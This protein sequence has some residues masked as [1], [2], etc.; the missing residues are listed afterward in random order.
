LLEKLCKAWALEFQ[1][2][3]L[4]GS[5]DSLRSTTYLQHPIF[6]SYHS[7]TAMLRYIRSLSDRD[8]ALDRTMI[9]LGSCTMKLNATTEMEAITW[10]EFAFLHPFAPAQQSQGTRKLIS[11][12]SKW[13]IDITGYD[14]VSLQPNAGSQG[15]FAGLLAIKNYLASNGE[16][17][18]DICLIPSSAHGTNAASAVMAGMR[19]VVVSCDEEGNVSLADLKEKIEQYR[20]ELAALMV[21]Y[22]STHGVFESEITTIC[23][24]IHDAGGQVYVD[25]ANLNAL[26]GL[27]QPGKFGADVSHLNLH[28]TFCIPHGG[29]GPGVGPVIARKH[30]APHLPNHPLDPTAGP[31]TGAGPISSAPFGS[32]LILPISWAYIRMMGAQGLTHATEVAI[33]SAN[34]I[35][36]KLS[37]HYPILYTGKNGLIAHECI[38]DLRDITKRTGV[39]VD[40]IAKRLMDYGFHAP[41]M[42]FPVAGTLMIEPTESEDVAEMDRFI[43][44]MIAIAKEIEAIERGELKVE[45]SPLRHAPH[46]ASDVL[47]DNWQ[48]PYSRLQAAFP[49]EE[50]IG[51][52]RRGKYWP[53]VGRVDGAYGDRNLVCA[54][55]PIE[56][57]AIN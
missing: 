47:A 19:V 38:I 41:T 1:T 53:T 55:E 9:P 37:D 46:T 15:E 22:P 4:I 40:D 44:A 5:I 3:Q 52:T 11:E 17:A 23:G 34:Y 45:D 2:E 8:L 43:S 29:G 51:L 18:R 20:G 31:L 12:L 36:K 16:G 26:V 49:A 24:M 33:L 13:L 42:S 35:A 10:P 57:L 27:A 14:A 28:K 21:T 50:E 7:E 32:A 6:T 48:R 39:T 56:S 30:L 25:G 54:C